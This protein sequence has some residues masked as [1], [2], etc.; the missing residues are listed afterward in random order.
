MI[1]MPFLRYLMVVP[2]VMGFTQAHALTIKHVSHDPIY[3][4]INAQVKIAIRF[5]LDSPSTVTLRIYDDREYLIK[6]TTRGGLKAGDNTMEWDG[7]DSNNRKVPPE[8]YR[9][10]LEASQGGENVTYDPGDI[11]GGDNIAVKNLTWN[12]E[13]NTLDYSITKNSRVSLRA[14]IKEG[15][16]LLASVVNWQPRAR[17]HYSEKWEGKDA[18]G[19]LDIKKLKDVMLFGQAYSLSNNTIIIGPYQN[20]SK[21]IE[22][23]DAGTQKRERTHTANK[24]FNFHGKD[25]DARKD[26]DM[27]VVL[28]DNLEKDKNNLPVFEG[29]VPIRINIPKEDLMR[30]QTSRFEPMLFVDGKY[31]SE[32]E[33]GFFPVTW[34]LN[35]QDYTQGEHYITVNIRGYDGQIGAASKR[36]TIRH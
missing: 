20:T 8:A 17:G 28:P 16:P 34:R 9:Y 26:F 2:F 30:M 12:K 29:N 21:Y 4:D 10:T 18:S 14:G 1:E 3:T 36:I 13:T 6:Q 31:V 19:T 25:A 24:M 22:S 35:S 27:N 32:L 15:G 23:L 7:T 5:A 33:S 11:T